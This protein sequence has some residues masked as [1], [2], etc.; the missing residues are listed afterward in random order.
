MF[1]KHLSIIGSTMSNQTDFRT[2]MDLIVKGVLEPAL[3]MLFPLQDA[4]DAQERLWKGEHFGKI[5]L[6]IG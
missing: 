6:D 1:A 5:T 2:V 4:A 3:D